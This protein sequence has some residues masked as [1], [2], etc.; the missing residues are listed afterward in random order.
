M[1][2]EINGAYVVL[3]RDESSLS[4]AEGKTLRRLVDS[5]NSETVAQLYG[6]SRLAIDCM[7]MNMMFDRETVERVQRKLTSRSLLVSVG[8]I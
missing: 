4:N 2:Q 8:K 6:V 1:I 3:P 7:C 5:L